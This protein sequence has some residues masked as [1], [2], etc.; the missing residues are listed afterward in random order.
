MV[1][2]ET[3]TRISLLRQGCMACFKSCNKTIPETSQ[4][5]LNFSWNRLPP[6]QKMY[7]NKTELSGCLISCWVYSQ[8]N[9]I[10]LNTSNSSNEVEV[11]WVVMSYSAAV[12]YHRLKGHGGSKV[13][14]NT[15][16]LPQHYA[17]SQPR[18]HNLNLHHCENIKY[19]F[20]SNFKLNLN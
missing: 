7:T 5:H 14:Q 8:F 6:S 12:G 1:Q 17:A 11:F 20:K 19:H 3:C 9:C 16:I 4:P 15:G 13:L 10:V 18:D 2:V